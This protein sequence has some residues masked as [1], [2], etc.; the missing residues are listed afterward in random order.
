MFR[1]NPY[2]ETLMG[3][4]GDTRI[5]EK[6][7]LRIIAEVGTPFSFYNSNLDR[8]ASIIGAETF[9]RAMKNIGRRSY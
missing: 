6:L 5:G 3:I 2:I 1:P 8:M 7:A 4:G 9:R